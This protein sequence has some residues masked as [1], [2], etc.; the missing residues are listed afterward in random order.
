[1]ID[2]NLLRK[3]PSLIK[4]SQ[5]KRGLDEKDIDF[6]LHLDEKWR[7]VKQEVDSLRAER[8]K[9][10]E[11]INEAKKHGRKIDDIIK[12]AKEIP[13]KIE[14][15]EKALIEL[16]EKRNEAIDNIP[17]IIDK[18]VPVGDASK[19][20]VLEIVKKPSKLSFKPRGHEE[21]LLQLDMLDIERASKVAGA[22]F[23]YL[24]KDV[25]KLNQ[26]LINFAINFLAKKNFILV[27]PPYMLK[28]DALK[29]ALNLNAFEDMIYKIENEDL[30]LIGTAEHALN[31]YYMNEVID[32]EKL[33]IRFAGMSPCFRKEAGSH[34]KDTKGIF[35]VHQFEK[36]EQ[37]IFCKQ[38]DSWK[39]FDFI[40]KNTK[41]MFKAL[42]I[43][44]RIVVLSS[45]DTGRIPTKTIDFEGWFPT[46]NEYREL[47]SCSNCLDY[48]A[49]RSNIKYEENGGRKFVHTLNN[50]AIATE[51][52]IVCII[53]N[54]QN[55]NGSITIPKVLVPYMNGQKVIGT[56]EKVKKK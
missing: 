44:F 55:K 24:K 4:E 41:E 27:Q 53:E 37:F 38:E 32:K 47:A 9:I 39:E 2:V 26:A 1:M 30:Y 20:K 49:R 15:K 14:E 11:S 42:G 13:K 6:I 17:N 43:P 56:K 34:G 51:R 54:Y 36:I 50:T 25:V 28:R 45:E 48:Q 8:N 7:N 46:Q 10:S 16:E 21:L 12:R 3:N 33:P 5:K 40:L 23:Y 19:N 29:G 35:R 22:R 18:S 31:A 52:M